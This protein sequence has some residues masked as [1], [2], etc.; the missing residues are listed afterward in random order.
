LNTFRR[1]AHWNS[2]CIAGEPAMAEQPGKSEAE[3]EGR[4]A[5]SFRVGFNAY[6][7]VIDFGQEYPPDAE[8]IHTRIVTSTPLARNLSETLERSLREYDSKF[9]R[10][11]GG[12]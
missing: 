12:D 4:Y 3:P 10:P 9:G 1:R 8:R 11:E 2:G 6:E 7:F 5:N